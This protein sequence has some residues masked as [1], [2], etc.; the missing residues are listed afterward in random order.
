MQEHHVADYFSVH[1][2]PN[3]IQNYA[4]GDVFIDGNW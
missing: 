1:V 2:I 4:V 3:E